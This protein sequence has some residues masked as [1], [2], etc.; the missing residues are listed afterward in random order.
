MTITAVP[1]VHLLDPETDVSWKQADHDVFVATV[2]N[3]YAGFI[4][5]DGPA[6]TVHTAHSEPIGTYR[7]LREA[8]AALG[9]HLTRSKTAAA[10]P[11]ARRRRWLALGR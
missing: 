9:Q 10:R 5:V 6:H 7:S 11:L 8:R 4:S 2:H 1:P 3:E